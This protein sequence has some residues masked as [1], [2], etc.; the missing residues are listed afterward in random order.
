MPSHAIQSRDAKNIASGYGSLPNEFYIYP[1]FIDGAW[2]RQFVDVAIDEFFLETFV[3]A[4]VGNEANFRIIL[5]EPKCEIHKLDPVL[6]KLDSVL[7]GRD[8]SNYRLLVH[9]SASTSFASG[10]L[11]PVEQRLSDAI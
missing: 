1:L 8:V 5:L 9:K 10:H 2:R 3:K 4:I 11:R 6:Q 7:S